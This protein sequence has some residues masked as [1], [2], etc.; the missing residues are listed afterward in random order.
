MSEACC[1]GACES[2]PAP[3]RRSHRAWPVAISGLLILA[4]AWASSRGLAIW[5]IAAYLPAIAFA[6]SRR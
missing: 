4:G 5:S 6:G 1:G 3:I 2:R